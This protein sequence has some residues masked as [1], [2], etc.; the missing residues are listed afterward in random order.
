MNQCFKVLNIL[1]LI[2]INSSFYSDEWKASLEFLAWNAEQSGADNWGQEFENPNMNNNLTILDVPFEINLGLRGSLTNSCGY[3]E[4]ALRYTWYSITGKRQASISSPGYI[5]SAY[6]GNYYIGNADGSGL[7]GPKYRYAKMKWNI[8]MN[9]IDYEFGT[10]YNATNSIVFSPFIGIKGGT[11]NQ[12][13]NT[14]WALP[15]VGS[16]T[17]VEDLE[18]NFWGIGPSIGIHTSWQL[19]DHISLF[20]NATGALVVGRWTF[21]D[22]YKNTQPKEVIIN[23]PS[24]WGVSP[25]LSIFMGFEY[26]LNCWSLRLGYESQLWLE[27][28]KLD[29]YNL[30]LMNNHL[31]VQGLTFGFDYKF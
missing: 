14:F 4:S 17:A 8:S 23:N 16:F 26:Q 13:I 1:F 25:M 24:R 28:M 9:I 10:S 2:F 29:I 18:N 27:Q 31:I 21:M 11:I 22:V 15:T 5:T 7:S 3:F 12:T 20:A 19:F 6:M 30:A